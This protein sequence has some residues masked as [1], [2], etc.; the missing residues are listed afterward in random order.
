MYLQFPFPRRK[1]PEKPNLEN[2]GVREWV[3]LFLS[4]HGE[5]NFDKE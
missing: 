2:V 1:Y 3:P 5:E 4:D